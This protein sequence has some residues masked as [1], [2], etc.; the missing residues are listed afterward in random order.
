MQLPDL[1][2][3]LFEGLTIIFVLMD[4]QSILKDKKVRGL[5]R[6]CLV[7]FATW[8]TWNLFY[9]NNLGQVLSVT[10]VFTCKLASAIYLFMF[11]YY[12]HLEENNK[13]ENKKVLIWGSVASVIAYGLVGIILILLGS[14]YAH[15]HKWPDG[16]NAFFELSA[17]AFKA[18]N[19]LALIKQK[20]FKGAN[21]W[22]IVFFTSWGAWNMFYYYHLGQ[23]LSWFGGFCIFF[24]NCWYLWLIFYLVWT[25]N[26]VH[27]PCINR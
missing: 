26:L 6:T 16:V 10:A 15:G 17:G 13:A 21:F 22:G 23:Y 8:S 1:I 19:C 20:E 3:G 27:K 9:Y 24:V 4:I 11:F 2:N 12:I 25:P 5:T 18:K 7:F 14:S